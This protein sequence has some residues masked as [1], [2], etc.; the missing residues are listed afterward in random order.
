MKTLLLISLAPL[1]LISRQSDEYNPSASPL[2]STTMDVQVEYGKNDRKIPLKIYLPESKQKVTMQ[3]APVILFSHGLGGSKDNNPYLGKHWAGRG[4]VVVFMQ[5][6]GSDSKVWQDTPRRDRL[7][8][9]KAAASYKS[10]Q[11]RVKDVPAVLDQLKKWNQKGQ[12]LDGRMDLERIGMSGHSFGA[13]TTQAVSGQNYR[14]QGQAF[15]DDRIKAS[16]AMSPSIPRRGNDDDTFA[17]VKIPWLLMTGTKDKSVINSTTP[18]DRQKVFTQLPDGDHFYELVLHNAEHSAFSER[19]VGGGQ[20]RNPNHHKAILALS[21]AFWD[22]YLKKDPAA[23][24]W[25]NGEG[26]KKI[27]EPKDRWQRK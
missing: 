15:T 22:A 25:L 10:F 19:R 18:E 4:Y 13:V 1:L 5:H 2:S 9:M 8:A 17:K 11:S 14:N 23:K 12:K 6:A 21:S 7:K 24:K 26:A 27:L 3:K 20:Q 16:V